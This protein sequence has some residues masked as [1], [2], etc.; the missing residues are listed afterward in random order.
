MSFIELVPVNGI[1]VDVPVYC[2]YTVFSNVGKLFKPYF[3]VYLGMQIELCRFFSFLIVF[4]TQTL[5]MFHVLILKMV[6]QDFYL[7]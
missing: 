1:I 6:Y 2:E 5:I 3:I 4:N 7:K